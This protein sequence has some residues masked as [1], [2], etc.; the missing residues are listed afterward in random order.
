[1]PRRRAGSLG[2]LLAPLLLLLLLAYASLAPPARSARADGAWLDQAPPANWNVAGA[3]LPPAPPAI[4]VLPDPRCAVQARP[5]ETEAD[6][7][8]AGAGW[9]VAGDY[10]A[11][12]G[13]Q[14]VLGLTHYDGMCR[15]MQYQEFVFLDGRFAGTISPAPMDSRSDGAGETE[16][17]LPSA[18]P[19]A[20]ALLV[21]A[22][23]RRYAAADPLCCPSASSFVT[24]RIE[25]SEDGPLLVP[26]SVSTS[27]LSPPGGPTPV[28][29]APP[30]TSG[31]PE[32]CSGAAAVAERI[33]VCLPSG[34]GTALRGRSVPRGGTS[35]L[36]ASG[37]YRILVVDGYPVPV[38]GAAPPSPPVLS[39]LQPA[40]AVFNL[41]DFE[42]SGNPGAAQVQAL[43]DLLQNRPPFG[44]LQAF[45]A[46][47]QGRVSLPQLASDRAASPFTARPQYLDLPWGAGVRGV[48]QAEP[49]A[50]AP[51]NGRL[52]YQFAGLTSD[53]RWLVLATFP[54]AVPALPA[55]PPGTP[56]PG[57]SPASRV[58]PVQV[59]LSLL[60]EA[61]YAPALNRLDALVRSIQVGA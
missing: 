54:L 35:G 28:P 46:G 55:A 17:I 47:P 18:D 3:A 4:Q 50:G 25:R 20:P 58:E 38:P 27:P 45:P 52:Q 24:Y 26:L 15:P 5:P 30:A 53:N 44:G 7:Q 42:A 23:F 16:A 41:G 36:P 32:A 21:G 61:L 13:V 60:D 6:R 14:V 49:E 19:A 51:A 34:V 8:V 29:G 40:I 39:P 2:R 48:V 22:T 10:R 31:P 37:A 56:A 11:G 43:R 9:T 59:Y 57:A 1:L 12:W 33:S